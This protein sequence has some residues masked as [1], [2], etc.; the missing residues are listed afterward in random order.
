MFS[1]GVVEK[2]LP[3]IVTVDPT[4][5]FKGDTVLSEISGAFIF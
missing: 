4:G 5:P 3:V 1:E 2:W